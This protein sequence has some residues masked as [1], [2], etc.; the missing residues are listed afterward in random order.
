MFC[1]LSL[2]FVCFW[3]RTQ[4]CYFLFRNVYLLP[5]KVWPV[6]NWV[7]SFQVTFT[8]LE[9]NDCTI[10][11]F[12]FYFIIIFKIYLFYCFIFGCIGSSLL[13]T[14]F[15]LLRWAGATLHCGARAS[16]CSGFSCSGAWA[17]GTRAPVVVARGLSSC[18][19]R[20][21]EHRLSSCGAR[22]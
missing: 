10:V 2:S 5:L 20:A 21:L 18:G 11:V 19:L 14:G 22:V 6:L 15:L 1:F 7:F 13:H 12:L 17:L 3:R 16:H 4:G 8:F 9:V